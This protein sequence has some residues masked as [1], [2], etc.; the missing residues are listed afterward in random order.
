MTHNM[1]DEEL[2]LGWR[3]RVASGINDLKR[4]VYATAREH[5]WWDDPNPNIGEKIALIHSEASEALE[6]VRDDV[7]PLQAIVYEYPA[8]FA[9][10]H[11]LNTV[12][13]YPD[14]DGTMGKPV[15]VASEMADIIIRVLDTCEHF[16]IP[17]TRALVEKH[18]Y[19][20]TRSHRHG[21][22]RF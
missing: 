11:G 13:M 5:G 10:Q 6:A 21:D 4:E 14:V 3:M 20:K 7:A 9:A 17:V 12:S 16:G 22:K 1:A 15:G 2:D 18:A 19:N 8:V